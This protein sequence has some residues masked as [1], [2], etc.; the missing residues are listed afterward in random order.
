ML[1]EANVPLVTL[2]G[3]GGVG[4]TR[5]ALEIAAGVAG[6]YADGITFVSL[7]T[8]TDPAQVLPAIALA[9]GVAEQSARY[10]HQL[11]MAALRPRQLLLVLDNIEQVTG[12]SPALAELLAACPAVQILATSRS[13]LHLRDER[14]YPVVPL[15][16][17]ARPRRAGEAPSL[18][19]IAR[20]DAVRL[21]AQRAEAVAAGFALTEVNAATVAEICRRVDGLP[22]AIELAAAR[23]RILS[24]DAL[25]ALLSRRLK[26]L[27]SGPRDLPVR[28]QTMRNTVAW[29][30]DLLDEPARILLRRLG[31]FASGCALA[32]ATAVANGDVYAVLDALTSLVDQSLLRRT[33]GLTDEPRFEMLETIREYAVEQLA[34]AGDEES[35]RRR[36]AAWCLAMAE[37]VASQ[38]TGPEQVSA[39][40]KFDTEHDNLRAAL[41]WALDRGEPRDALRLAVALWRFWLIRG[42]AV[43][44]RSW[45][46]RTLD[47][48]PEAPAALRATAFNAIGALAHGRGDNAGAVAG[49]SAALALFRET[50]DRRGA[51][52]ALNNLGILAWYAGDYPRAEQLHGEALALFRELDDRDGIATSLNALGN[53]VHHRGDYVRATALHAESVGLC[54][55]LRDDHS[56]AIAAISLG[57]SL[58]EGGDDERAAAVYAE[59]LALCRGLGF[60]EGIAA[61]LNN[62]GD[63][64]RFAGEIETARERY[65][66]SLSRYRELENQRGIAVSLRNL[67]L[68]VREHG[69]RAGAISFAR[70]ALELRSELGDRDG[71]AEGLEDLAALAADQP[72]RALRLY[73]AADHLRAT[74]D[75]PVR[76][77]ER[78]VR[79]RHLAAARSRLDPSTRAK[80]W[81]AGRSLS[82]EAAVT[83]AVSPARAALSTIGQTSPG[84]PVHP[85]SRRELE[86]L[87]LLTERLSDKEIADALSISPRTVM[88]HVASIF[89]KLA[90][91][92]RRAA[93]AYALRHGLV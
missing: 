89:N 49:F 59:T 80:A 73:A 18:V 62:L 31:V 63:L 12:C 1:T 16:L 68:L 20:S 47:A 24:P 52:N 75:A 74:I 83:E 78:A 67:G 36:H 34:A 40:A 64:A 61:C 70:E 48:A 91:N 44:G 30:D 88:A 9:V 86:V 55:E 37:D 53:V 45:L 84:R 28:Q 17:P 69:D 8:V 77:S 13:P 60:Q 5:L 15:A 3:P 32:G 27:T 85:L 46:N 65:D 50:G 87:G 72:E 42:H 56:L 43:E 41:T 10:V 19:E 76:P 93:A 38:L 11:L 82:P 66:E 22:L 6:A 29:S 14:E 23:T 92:D 57:M 35:C 7:A 25:L 2:T 51:A 4:K 81:S 26:I 54:R 90:V 39:L 71:I 58:A 79:D 33:G 21:F